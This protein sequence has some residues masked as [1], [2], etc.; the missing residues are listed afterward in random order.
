MPAICAKSRRHDRRKPQALPSHLVGLVLLVERPH[1]LTAVGHLVPALV[2]IG[3]AAPEVEVPLPLRL[4]F[5]ELPVIGEVPGVAELAAG[6]P[7]AEPR[8]LGELLWAKE[9][10]PE[11][12]RTVANA[13]LLSFMAAPPGR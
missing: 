9:R 5:I 3:I 2:A 4:G 10:L 6:S 12:I 8:P 1:A 13:M 11:K 7:V